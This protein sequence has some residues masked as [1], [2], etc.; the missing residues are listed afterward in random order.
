MQT[1]PSF[2]FLFLCGAL[3]AGCRTPSRAPALL[4]GC[5]PACPG[6]PVARV[7]DVGAALRGAPPSA[8][9]DL[10]AV[11]P[12]APSEARLLCPMHPEVGADEPGRCPQCGMWLVPRDQVVEHRHER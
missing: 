3:A 4:Q 7:P 9:P 11:E 12:P 10:R 2:S 8:A 6:A 5:H 1:L